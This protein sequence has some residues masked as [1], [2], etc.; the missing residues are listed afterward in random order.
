MTEKAQLQIFKKKIA[1]VLVVA[2]S[3]Y[4]IFISLSILGKLG[5][6]VLFC[7]ILDP[8]VKWV[9]RYMPRNNRLLAVLV[10]FAALGLFVLY[11]IAQLV[12]IVVTQLSGSISELERAAEEAQRSGQTLSQTLSAMNPD[13]SVSALL[14]YVAKAIPSVLSFVAQSFSSLLGTIFSQLMVFGFVLFGLLEGPYWVRTIKS[15]LPKDRKEEI[16]WTAQQAYR[17]VTSY[18]TGNLFI[19]LCAGVAAMLFCLVTGMPYVLMLGLA[20]AICDLIPMVGAYLS[21]IV[22]GLFGL[23]LV[24]PEVGFAAVIYV[25][26]YQQF[27]NQI[28]SPIV[29]NKAVK[30]T[31]LTALVSVSIGGAVAGLLGA[32]IAIPVGGTVQLV[33][34]R[35]FS[36]KQNTTKAKA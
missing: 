34:Q 28:L 15:V 14:P 17:S 36:K 11:V 21:G 3:L 22:L 35:Y 18:I 6:A 10:T 33:L 1:I 4:A 5:I 20:V 23:I 26:I 29:Y 16:V 2:L 32:L 30:L 13:A 12:P 31:P 7:V 8:L 27:E 24:G 25:T 19:S 9:M